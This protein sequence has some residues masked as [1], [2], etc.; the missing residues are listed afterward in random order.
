MLTCGGKTAQRGRPC[1]ELSAAQDVKARGKSLV[2][3]SKWLQTLYMEVILS[4]EMLIWYSPTSTD[5]WPKWHSISAL[6]GWPWGVQCGADAQDQVIAVV[7][8]VNTCWLA[9]CVWGTV[10]ISLYKHYL[11]FTRTIWGSYQFY[12]HFTGNRNTEELRS[13]ASKTL[14]HVSDG[15]W[16][17]TQ[18]VTVPAL[19][20]L[21]GCPYVSKC[22]VACPLSELPVQKAPGLSAKKGARR[23]GGHG[24]GLPKAEVNMVFIKRMRAWRNIYLLHLW[25]TKGGRLLK[26]WKLWKVWVRHIVLALLSPSA[27]VPEVTW[28]M[29]CGPLTHIPL[30]T[31]WWENHEQSVVLIPLISLGLLQ[32]FLLCLISLKDYYGKDLE[33]FSLWFSMKTMH[34]D[35]TQQ[36]VASRLNKNSISSKFGL[37]FWRFPNRNTMFCFVE[38]GEREVLL[39]A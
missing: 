27:S 11:V 6:E 14:E 7:T 32:Y 26:F 18:P 4:V 38:E 10:L 19:A 17:W 28:A 16:I 5:P 3:P 39:S 33:G 25:S 21:T 2:M 29:C 30:P 20:L 12:F 23:S 35:C 13:C 8:I 24:W 1:R 37:A 15:V 34:I 31:P 9:F 22:E 36:L